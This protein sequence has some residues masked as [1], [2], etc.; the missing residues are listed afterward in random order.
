MAKKETEQVM[1]AAGPQTVPAAPEPRSQRG[2]RRFRS[3]A[4]TAME[5]IRMRPGGT[6]GPWAYYLRPDG[7]TLRDALILYPNGG[8]GELVTM[9][10]GTQRR[11]Y[12][13]N[14]EYYHARQ[15]RK[16]FVYLGQALTSEAVR[17]L[18]ET[19]GRNREDEILFLEDEIAACEYTIRTAETPAVRDNQRKRKAQ[20]ERRLEVIRN[21]FDPE[22]LVAELNDIARAQRLAGLDPNMLAVLREMVGEVNERVASLAA[23]LAR[24]KASSDP[25]MEAAMPRMKVSYGNDPT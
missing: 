11:R 17:L 9:P 5:Q 8:E 6:H 19:I 12:G 21:G 1:T 20:Y 10:D 23:R 2:K 13:D 25:E 24:G 16:G 15:Q 18:V 4:P 22:A 7:A 3:P 14:S